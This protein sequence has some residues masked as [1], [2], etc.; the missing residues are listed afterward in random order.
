MCDKVVDD[1]LPAL[2]LIP[3]WSITSKMVKDL[4]TALNEDQSIFYFNEDFDNVVLSKI[5]AMKWVFLI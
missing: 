4:F 2:K 3:D 1:S 5:L